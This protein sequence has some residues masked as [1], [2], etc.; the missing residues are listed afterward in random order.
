MPS[1]A[2]QSPRRF[3][4]QNRDILPRLPFRSAPS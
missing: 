2:A 4:A 3:R 1:I